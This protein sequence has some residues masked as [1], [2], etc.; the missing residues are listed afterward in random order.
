MTV[1]AVLLRGVNV[2]G[3][4]IKMADL[5]E[6]L[7]EPPLSDVQTLLASGN[8]V[9][10]FDGSGKDLKPLVED[11]PPIPRPKPDPVEL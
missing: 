9:C 10:D 6:T 1:Y 7:D 11:F 8:V 3:I 5:R 2:G 4:N